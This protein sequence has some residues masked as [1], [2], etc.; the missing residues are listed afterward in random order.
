[1]DNKPIYVPLELPLENIPTIIPGGMTKEKLE[2]YSNEIP[3][4]YYSIFNINTKE[5]D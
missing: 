4:T 3:N 5:N 2:F 1:M